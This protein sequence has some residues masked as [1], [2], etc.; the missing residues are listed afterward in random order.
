MECKKFAKV[1]LQSYECLDVLILTCACSEIKSVDTNDKH[2]VDDKVGTRCGFVL[3]III[4][5][6]SLK[7][8][9]KYMLAG[10]SRL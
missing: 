1:V 2:L 10:P 7:I 8:F 5:R 9:E 4:E 6:T 3:I